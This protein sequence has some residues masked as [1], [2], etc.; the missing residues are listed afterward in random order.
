LRE[1]C[2]EVILCLDI[3]EHLEKEEGLLLLDY[4]ERIA[5]KVVIVFTPVG[6]NP[7]KHLENANPWQ[8]HKSSWCPSE[9]RERG[10][11]VIGENGLRVLRGERTIF[12][13]EQRRM[14]AVFL[15]MF[16]N[17]SQLFTYWFPES[18]YH[19]LC[20]KRMKNS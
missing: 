17:F 4:V 11:K 18:A 2:T 14:V 12:L 8:A 6:W 15:H 10:Y 19:M 5:T 20:I 13:F 7:K 1:R 16:A 3:I 9:F